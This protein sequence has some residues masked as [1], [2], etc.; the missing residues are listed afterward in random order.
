MRVLE[1]G[2]G[3]GGAGRA[4]PRASKRRRSPSHAAVHRPLRL[5]IW[6]YALRNR[7]RLETCEHPL[8]VAEPT[9]NTR[10]AR[11][12]M[13]ELLF[14]KFSPPALFLAKN[15]VLSSFAVGRPT[16]LVIDCGASGAH[17]LR[18]DGQ[19]A[20]AAPAHPPCAGTTIS[21]VHDGYA[22]NKCLNRNP[23]GGQALTDLTLRVAQSAGS[24]VRPRF[25]FKRTEKDGSI[26]CTPVATRGVT[27]SYSLLRTWEVAADIKES[28]C[29]LSEGPLNEAE[30][31]TAPSAPYEL[32]D[33]R[34][35]EFGAERLKV[36]ELLFNPSLLG[37][38]ALPMD[39]PSGGIGDLATSGGALR[40]LPQAVAEVIGKCDVDLRKE[41]YGGVVLTGGGSLFAGLKERLEKELQAGAPAALRVKVLA[42]ASTQERKYGVWLGGSILASLGSFQQL[43]MSKAE[44][45]EHGASYIHKKAP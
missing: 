6:E 23:L 22:L 8:M 24:E 15:S 2:A 9:H 5:Q 1:G 27:A 17:P 40:G 38:F 28:C 32:P 26:F 21:A 14:E 25:S 39:L 3:A 35:F 16:S 34:L 29:R 43:W 33:G 30:A 42:S 41:L 45:E 44:Y 19:P 18:Q 13:V 7:L 10:A 31:A 36:P 4:S 11:E 20:S 12:K 37:S